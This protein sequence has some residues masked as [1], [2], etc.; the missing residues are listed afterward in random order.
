MAPRPDWKVLDAYQYTITR[1]RFVWLLD[2][3]YAPYGAWKDWIRIGQDSAQIVTRRGAAPFVLHFAASTSQARAVPRYWRSRSEIPRASRSRP[4]E[5]LRIAIDPGHIGGKWAKL[6]E[7]WFQIGNSKPVTEGDMTLYVAKL[8]AQRLERLGAK[9]YLTRSSAK[10]VTSARPKNLRRAAA[11]ELRANGQRPSDAAVEHV[12]N[13]LFYRMSEIRKRAELVN[14]RIRPDLVVCLHFNAEAW[15]DPAN[16][17]LVS[18]NHLHFLITGAFSSHELSFEDQRMNMLKKLLDQTYYEEVEVTKDIATSMKKST[19]LPA[20]TYHGKN[21]VNAAG[22]PYIW[23]R[24]LLAN[25]LFECP[26]VYIEPYVMNSRD[27]FYR[28]QA[29]DYRGT[30][31]V[32]GRKQASIFREYASGLAQGILDFYSQR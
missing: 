21:A 1:E 18:K 13:I 12:S 8:T 5:G 29:G 20:F 6:E 4:L 27:V 30:R 23:G 24:N 10:P 25:R 26:V 14:K 11:A 15:G 17:A 16:P 19:G 3:V 22:N 9:V 2:K 31:I 28:I 32:N 7:R